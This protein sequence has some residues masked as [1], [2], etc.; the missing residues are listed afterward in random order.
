MFYRLWI[1]K[2]IK[3][4]DQARLSNAA[5]RNNLNHAYTVK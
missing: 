5:L 2:F 4:S 3:K 1:E